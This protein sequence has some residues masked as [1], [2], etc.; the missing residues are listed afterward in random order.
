M[1]VIMLELGIFIP[2]FLF[3][4]WTIYCANKTYHERLLIINIIK[5]K[6]KFIQN[7]NLFK[8][9]EEVSDFHHLIYNI[10]LQDW[11]KLYPNINISRFHKK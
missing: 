1:Q 2:F 6:Q 10:T 11:D 4:V 5:E 3:F 7:E 9:F 8:K